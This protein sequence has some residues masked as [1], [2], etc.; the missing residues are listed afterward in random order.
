MIVRIPRS[1]LLA[2][3]STFYFA[4]KLNYTVYFEKR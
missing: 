2:H 1:L 3:T 4:K